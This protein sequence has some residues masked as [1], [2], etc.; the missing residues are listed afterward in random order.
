MSIIKL[1]DHEFEGWLGVVGQTLDI[2]DFRVDRFLLVFAYLAEFIIET[3]P[4]QICHLS[5]IC[6]NYYYKCIIVL[7]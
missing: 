5:F 6:H 3:V 4:H 1:R 2:Y 7:S